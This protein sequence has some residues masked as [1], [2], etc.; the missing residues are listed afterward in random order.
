[1]SFLL[2]LMR[3][4]CYSICLITQQLTEQ[5]LHML[6]KG[7]IKV[8]VY[9]RCVGRVHNAVLHEQP[10]K[11]AHNIYTLLS[12]LNSLFHI[13]A[14]AEPVIIFLYIFHLKYRCFTLILQAYRS[15]IDKSVKDGLKKA[16]GVTVLSASLE[17]KVR[18]GI[19][20]ALI[21]IQ[22]LSIGLIM[23]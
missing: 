9:T 6:Y 3:T 12:R 10:E 23:Y 7:S 11:A 18:I 14:D 20:H 2:G 16:V 4:L 8:S 21:L 5:N 1:M 13:Q 19:V 22:I 17:S 15:V